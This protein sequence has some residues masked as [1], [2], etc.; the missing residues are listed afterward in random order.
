MERSI[1]VIDMKA[2]YASVECHDRGLN[3]FTTPLAVCDPTRGEGTIVLSVSPYLKTLGY[4]SVC[5][6]RDLKDV[7]G[8]ILAM[9]RMQKYIEKS[10]EILAIALDFVG[11]DD[12]HVYSIDEF[13]VNLGP[14]LKMYECTP[15]Q[16]TQKIQ[17]T[18]FE[19]TGLITT[20]GVSYNMLLA[21]VALDCDAKNKPPYISV[22][23]KKDIKNKLWKITPLSKM[24]GINAGYERK[25]NNLGITTVGQLAQTNKDFMRDKFGVI[26]EQLWEHAN[27][28]DNTD[29]REK[30]IPRETSLSI[31]QVLMRD[32]S[33]KEAELILKEMAD[34]LCIRLRAQK[35]KT[36]CISLTILYT[37]TEGGGF[38]HQCTLDFPTDDSELI[39]EDIYRLYRKY[40]GNHKVRR[41]SISFSHLTDEQ[42]LQ[43]SLFEEP[44]ETIS[45]ADLQHVIDT[46]KIKYGKDIILRASSLLDESTIKE[47]HKQIGGHRR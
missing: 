39:L 6:R 23:T 5:R 32:Y 20:A 14:Y 35:Q 45:R 25:L 41:I 30:Y 43:L 17:Q 29:L 34:E 18:I 8:L 28:I 1:A 37:V 16:L 26:G 36:S 46:L 21:K 24:W 31:G 2:F 13:F 22:W 40:V 12:I 9:P 19:K 33:V 47:R 15:K 7:K 27:G 44:K 42:S 11:E 10:A 38:S 3:P 4:P